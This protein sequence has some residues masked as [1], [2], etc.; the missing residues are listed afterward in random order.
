MA[1]DIREQIAYLV[2]AR[3]RRFRTPLLLGAAG[4]FLGSSPFL[5][6]PDFSVGGLFTGVLGGVLT[7]HH[8][9]SWDTQKLWALI[10]ARSSLRDLV[11]PEYQDQYLHVFNENQNQSIKLIVNL[12]GDIVVNPKFS[13]RSSAHIF[14]SQP[15][16][17]IKEEKGEKAKISNKV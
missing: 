14:F 2:K 9:V 13:L 15:N 8:T 17:E 7:N 11:L 6:Q 5:P 16:K 12:F 10:K 3:S 1:D 4:Y